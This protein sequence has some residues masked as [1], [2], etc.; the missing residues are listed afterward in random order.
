MI[1]ANLC[2]NAQTAA[3]ARSRKKGVAVNATEHS[4]GIEAVRILDQNS[5][6][7]VVCTT[8]ATVSAQAGEGAGTTCALDVGTINP[9]LEP[10]PPGF[11]FPSCNSFHAAS[12]PRASHVRDAL[13]GFRLFWQL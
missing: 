3:M 5:V 2:I 9:G 10:S 12:H 11:T 13:S 4:G 6:L 8:L 1:E 7:A